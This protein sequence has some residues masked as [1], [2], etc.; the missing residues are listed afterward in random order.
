MLMVLEQMLRE[1][2]KILVKEVVENE[3]FEIKEG[4]EDIIPNPSIYTCSL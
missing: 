3:M 4:N 1:L 2:I